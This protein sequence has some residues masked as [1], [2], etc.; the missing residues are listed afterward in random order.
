MLLDRRC[1]VSDVSFDID[2]LGAGEKLY[3]FVSG[4]FNGLG[5]EDA[6]GTV[7]GWKGLIELDHMA[8]D[9]GRPFNQGN[10]RALVGD[11]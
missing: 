1:E 6:G 10:L 3:I 7:Q 9:K 2:H 11:R 4:Y 8:T 5:G